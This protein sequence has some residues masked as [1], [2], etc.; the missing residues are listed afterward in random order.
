VEGVL[1]K[2]GEEVGELRAVAD[3]EARSR[4][5]GDLLFSLVNVARWLDLDAE[6]ALRSTCDRFTRRYAQMETRARTW[7][8]ELSEL[9]LAEQDRLWEE[10]KKEKE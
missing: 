6:S 4:E 9:S 1:D 3:T 8:K 2:L 5:L 7:G 10:A